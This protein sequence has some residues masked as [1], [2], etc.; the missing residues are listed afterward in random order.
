MSL[1]DVLQGNTAFPSTGDPA[2]DARIA[3]Q[4]RLHAAREAEGLCP[5]GCGPITIDSP[6]HQ[7]CAACGFIQERRTLYVGDLSGER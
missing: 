6:T 1:R 3:E 7:H 4:L 2:E 5:N